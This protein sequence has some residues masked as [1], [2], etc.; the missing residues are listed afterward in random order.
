MNLLREIANG[1]AG[2]ISHGLNAIDSGL[3]DAIASN[4]GG[5]RTTKTWYNVN[6]E[7]KTENKYKISSVIMLCK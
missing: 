3:A 2:G 1:V 6:S 4:R 7:K 5:R